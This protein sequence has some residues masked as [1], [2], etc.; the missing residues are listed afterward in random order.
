MRSLTRACLE[1]CCAAGGQLGNSSGSRDDRI[2]PL[3][4]RVAQVQA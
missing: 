4:T 2:V 1:V 3:L